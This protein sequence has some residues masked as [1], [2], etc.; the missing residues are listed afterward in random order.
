VL[1]AAAANLQVPLY[2][3]YA[4]ASGYGVGATSLAFA[5]YVSLLLPM[6]IFAGG[7]SD[8]IGRKGPILAAL[9]C[10]L[11]ATTAL[12]FV[13]NLEMVA[14]A[15]VLQG[16]AIAFAAGTGTAWAAELDQMANQGLGTSGARAASLV[17]ITTALGFGAGACWTALELM[18]RPSL[19]PFAFHGFALLLTLA[20]GLVMLVPETRAYTRTAAILRLPLFAPDTWISG[21]AIALGWS[22]VGIVIAVMP[23]AL[24]QLGLSAWIG[25]ALFMVNGG[26]GLT[27]IATRH[28]NGVTQVRVGLITLPIGLSLLI[29]GAIAGEIGALIAGAALAGTA[30]HGTLYQGG[31]NLAA[32][33]AGPHR[34]RAASGYFV[35]AYM[36]LCLPAIG[37]GFLSDAMGRD[38]ALIT[39]AVAGIVAAIALSL[40]L[41]RARL[42]NA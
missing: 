37:I 23:A 13:P 39:F 4:K 25:V 29:F 27:Q 28:W 33:Q 36:G 18:V 38:V 31:L 8:R 12:I 3:A 26:G 20:L 40:A 6:L 9:A 41:R 17:S 35:Y 34:A 10:A 16:M 11:L 15:R 1:V 14:A 24:D 19:D 42:A 5:C 32:A 21:L 22:V 30:T 7:L 2:P